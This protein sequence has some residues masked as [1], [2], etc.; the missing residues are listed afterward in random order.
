MSGQ[1]EVQEWFKKNPKL[2]RVD[3]KNA[4]HARNPKLVKQNRSECNGA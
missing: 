3:P 4:A 2:P 1:N